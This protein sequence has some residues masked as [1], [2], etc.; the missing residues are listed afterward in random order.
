M[1]CSPKLSTHKTKWICNNIQ[2]LL[3]HKMTKILLR[4]SKWPK[5]NIHNGALVISGA[6]W[7]HPNILLLSKLPLLTPMLNYLFA[8]C[9]DVVLGQLFA[10]HELLNPSVQLLQR[11]LVV[12]V[13]NGTHGEGCGLGA[14]Q[15][16]SGPQDRRRWT[17]DPK[18]LREKTRP[19]ITLSSSPGFSLSLSSVQFSSSQ[20][21][22]LKDWLMGCWA[23]WRGTGLIWRGSVS[24]EE[25]WGRGFDSIHIGQSVVIRKI[26]EIQC[27]VIWISLSITNFLVFLYQERA[28]AECWFL[29]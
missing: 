16:G 25:D 6:I 29:I 24:L 4:W 9:L 26:I 8:E 10:V 1:W 12:G 14:C 11:G 22:R 28:F 15:T 2:R 5:F 13:D 21:A 18:H 7:Q 3:I 17:T 20:S 27:S 23:G 19:T